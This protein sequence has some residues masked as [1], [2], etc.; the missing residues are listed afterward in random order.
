M[1]TV[2]RLDF[3]SPDETREPDK[4]KVAVVNTNNGSVAR[5]IMQP[6][7]TWDD[8]VKPVV[9]GESCQVAHLGY[10]EQGAIMI[11]SDDGTEMTFRAGDVY[12]LAPGHTAQIVGDDE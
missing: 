3:D 6:G 12:F 7:W 1:E 11:S 2:R 5:F 10:V 9:G 8:C 4:T